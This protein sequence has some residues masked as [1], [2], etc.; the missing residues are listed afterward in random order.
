MATK[1]KDPK[2]KINAS[3]SKALNGMKNKVKKASK[4][5]EDQIKRYQEVR[6]LYIG[7][8]CLPLTL[9]R[10]QTNTSASIPPSSNL[11]LLLQQPV[12]RLRGTMR[13]LKVKRGKM[14]SRRLERAEKA[15][16]ILLNLSLKFSRRSMR[17]VVKRYV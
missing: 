14:D 16:S 11:L 3:N 12:L 5:Y 2:K 1:E 8:Q 4:E 17:I 10:T 6:Q 15:S 7:G 9:H 13:S